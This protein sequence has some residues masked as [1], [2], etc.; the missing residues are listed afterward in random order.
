MLKKAASILFLTGS[1]ISCRTYTP[2]VN[3]DLHNIDFSEVAMFEKGVDC[4]RRFLGFIPVDANETVINA[5]KRGKIRNVKL[6]DKS[7]G[8]ALFPPGT[9]TCV[10]VYGTR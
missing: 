4:S 1:L 10:I 9:K 5:V 8:L 2:V 3:S 7:H 6:V